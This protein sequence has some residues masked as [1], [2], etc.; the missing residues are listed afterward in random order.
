MATLK[1]VVG[2][3]LLVTVLA[4]CAGS[5]PKQTGG[6]ILGGATGAL[7]GSQFGKGSGRLF[8]VAIG[9]LAGS[10][11]G[12]NIGYQMDERDKELAQ[13]TMQSTLERAPDHQ[14]H[15]WVNPNTHH[16]GKFKVVKTQEIPSR[17]IV[18]RDYVHTVIIDGQEEKVHGRACRDMRDVK[19]E[20]KVQK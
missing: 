7:I 12:G 11:L 14:V 16:S 8:G 2:T 17:N 20:W 13:Q 9:A 1:K 3:S 6:Q 18:C 10:Y 4:G 15:T 19:G 5:G